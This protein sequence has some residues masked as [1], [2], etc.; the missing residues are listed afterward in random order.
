MSEDCGL[1]ELA[2]CIPEKIY[3]FFI[4]LLNSP[5][6]PLLDQIKNLLSEPINIEIFS[7]LWAL[8]VYIISIFYGLL[9]L[10]AGFNF[11]ISGHDVYRREKAKSWMRNTFLIIFFVQGSY[12]FYSLLLEISSLLNTGALSLINQNFFLLTVDNFSNVGLE[13]IFTFFYVITLFITIIFLVLRYIL[14]SV[15]IIF[16]PLGL[17]FYFIPLLENYGKLVLNG[18]LILIFITFPQI[19]ILLAGSKLLEIPIFQDFKILVMISSFTLVNLLMI[20]LLIFAIIKAA[21]SILHSDTGRLTTTF[22]HPS[23]LLWSK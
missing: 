16:F 19:L 6:Q 2:S 22:Y 11:I 17:F 4:N 14:V 13:F 1:T 7:S 8:I 20:F 9:F 12:F 18:L 15:G 21:T 3:D 10:Y 5:L 23:R